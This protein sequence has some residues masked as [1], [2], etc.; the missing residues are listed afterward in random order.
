MTEDNKKHLPYV[1]SGIATRLHSLFF[2]KLI[3]YDT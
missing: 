2:Q 3:L 1:L